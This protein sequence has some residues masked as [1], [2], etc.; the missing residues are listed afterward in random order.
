M[1]KSSPWFVRINEHQVL[2]NRKVIGGKA[3]HEQ[4]V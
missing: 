3:R 2:P 4:H 1:M